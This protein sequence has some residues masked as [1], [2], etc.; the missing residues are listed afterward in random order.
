MKTPFHASVAVAFCACIAGC[1]G[2]GASRFTAIPAAAIREA[3]TVGKSTKADVI[4]AFGKTT[5]VTFDSGFEVWVYQYKG[6]TPGK[7][8]FVLLF[9]PSGV[10]AKTRLRPAPLP[11]EA[12][13]T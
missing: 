11:G 13:K 3:V 12:K 1:A 5:T 6:D 9:D 7:N 2:P 4:A 8:E 10:V